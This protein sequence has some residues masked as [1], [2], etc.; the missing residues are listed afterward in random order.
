MRFGI[1]DGIVETHVASSLERAMQAAGHNVYNTGKIGHGFK[2]ASS[3]KE[4][5]KLSVHLDELLA[6]EPDVIFVFRPA[7]LPYDLL[8]RA[9]SS[10]AKLVVWLSDDPVLW[11]LSYGPVL[12]EYDV[13]LHC[14]TERVLRFYEEQ[15]G[16]PTGVNIPFWTDQI[17]FPYVFGREYR[18]TD[19]LFLGNVHDTVRRNRYFDLGSLRSSVRI[20]GSVATD[21]FNLWGGFLDSDQEVVQA[22]ARSA[23]AINIPQFFKDHYGL[24]TW[25]PGLDRLGFFQ[26]PSR[27]IQYA[28]MGLPII[29]LVPTPQDLQSFPEIITVNSMGEL[30][31]AIQYVAHAPD[32]ADL[33]VRT[34]QRFLDNY[35]AAAR[36]MAIESLLVDDSWRSL[37]AVDRADWFLQFVPAAEDH[38]KILGAA[39]D[40]TRIE[41]AESTVIGDT[42]RV[43]PEQTMNIMVIGTGFQRVTSSAAVISRAMRA[44]GHEVT[45]CDAWNAPMLAPDPDDE[46]KYVL[47]TSKLQKSKA[48]T[49]DVIFVTGIDFGLTQSGADALTKMGIKLCVVGASFNIVD[50]KLE[51]LSARADLVCVNNPDLAAAAQSHGLSNVKHVPAMV[52][53]A[54]ITLTSLMEK[55]RYEPVRVAR[56]ALHLDQ[57]APAFKDFDSLG[58]GR[59]VIEESP[60][61]L[62][63]LPRLAEALN[64]AVILAA[65]DASRPGP[66]P[67]ELLPFAL[68]SGALVVTPRG[69]GPMQLG[70]PGVEVLCVREAGELNR[71][72]ARLAA[73][74]GGEAEELVTAARKLATTELLAERRLKQILNTLMSPI[75]EAG[76]AEESARLE[77]T[78]GSDLILACNSSV[79]VYAAPARESYTVLRIEVQHSFAEEFRGRLRFD[80]TALATGD[81]VTESIQYDGQK[82]IAE[83]HFPKDRV[84]GK[85]RFS[86]KST[87]DADPASGY[88]GCILATSWRAGRA[89]NS[90]AVFSGSATAQHYTL[91]EN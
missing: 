27:V 15:F 13:V 79:D 7:S 62:T 55:R 58:G 47:N 78:P 12:D 84:G 4:I 31:E 22:G 88:Q 23:V 71:K 49:P 2:F 74:K 81:T 64:V 65:H 57:Q 69:I 8:R 43:P 90:L 89:Q 66:L 60:K 82:S 61:E 37:S 28:A 25:F 1:Y 36:V 42:S 72:V 75:T 3:K 41:T 20:H 19:A 44:I 32:L 53:Q 24:E 59:V 5:H 35:S 14:G 87:G 56:R 30:D 51:R 16:R 50:S 11:D 48:S 76:V 63:S 73:S 77:M 39:P 52:D 54:F 34:H 85:I 26:Y 91:I 70:K 67:S 68:A 45:E 33:S 46:F 29:S 9:K 18:E 86:T 80:V 6:W 17:S 21:Y 40:N 38:A 10:G 83:F